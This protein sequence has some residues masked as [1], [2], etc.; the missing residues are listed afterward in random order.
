[1]SS[2]QPAREALL[3]ALEQALDRILADLPGWADGFLAP[4]L[5]ALLAAAEQPGCIPEKLATQ[6][7]ELRQVI[8]DRAD[9]DPWLNAVLAAEQAA[10]PKA[11]R[12]LSS[13]PSN[14]PLDDRYKNECVVEP[15]RRILAGIKSPAPKPAA[16]AKPRRK[17][18]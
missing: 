13:L 6:F 7:A 18:S 3:A 12:P 5:T 1:M 17:S 9:I 4:R 10:V 15:V 2:T 11:M 16:P 8:R 14:V